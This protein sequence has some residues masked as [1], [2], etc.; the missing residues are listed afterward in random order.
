[1]IH[2]AMFLVL[3]AVFRMAIVGYLGL[4]DAS[5]TQKA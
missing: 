5:G 3:L 4:L 2:L 1:M